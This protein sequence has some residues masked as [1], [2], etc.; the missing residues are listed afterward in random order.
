MSKV[1]TKKSGNFRFA[2]GMLIYAVVFLL[3]TAVGLTYF[4]DYMEAYEESRPKTAVNAYM[5]DLTE[6]HVCDLSQELIAQIDKNIQ[7]EEQSRAYIMNAIDGITCAKKSR[8]ST[9][10]RQVYVLRTGSAVIGEFSIIQG[11]P[12]KYGFAPWQFEQESFDVSTL[13]LF[14]S[15]YAV[16]VPHDH[17]VTVNGYVLDDSYIIE[18][19][20]IYEVLEAYYDEYD[21]PYR[22]SYA[23]EPVLGELNVVITDPDGNEAVFDENTDWTA[24]YHNCTDEET[25]AL[26]AFVPTY[27]DAYVSFTSSRRNSRYT[28]YNRLMKL[29]VADSEFATR[30]YDAIEGFEFGQT[31]GSKIVSLTPHHVVRLAE[32]KYLY[33]V[34]YEVDT[35]GHK[36][37]VRTTTNARIVVAQT[38]N[39]LKTEA[40]SVY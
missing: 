6:E 16:T 31:V 28:Y 1:K 17:Q 12:G 26:D 3:I 2:I 10:T 24:Y 14:G 36:G 23:V 9:L 5:Q 19:K 40:M 8:E 35:I 33:D 37:T 21:L 18:D 29:V 25:A 7:I 11:E 13:D 30:L 39:G 22:V 20:I 32:G 4:W 27:I 34:T 38:E 15:G